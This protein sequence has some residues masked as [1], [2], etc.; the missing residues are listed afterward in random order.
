MR[1]FNVP[2]GWCPICLVGPWPFCRI[3][4][5]L[6]FP[7]LYKKIPKSNEHVA[8]KHAE[9]IYVPQRMNTLLLGCWN[10]TDLLNIF[11]LSILSLQILPLPPDQ[12]SPHWP[13][14]LRLIPSVTH[15]HTGPDPLILCQFVKVASS[16]RV[17]TISVCIWCVPVFFQV[18]THT[19]MK[20]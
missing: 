8:I 11:M 19:R 16:I 6:K 5:R 3:N 9:H 12:Q 20:Y 15:R 2:W 1:I 17:P 7:P 13:P 10:W 14:H 18:K 4:T